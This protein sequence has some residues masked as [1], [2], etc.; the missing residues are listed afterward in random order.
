MFTTLTEENVGDAYFAHKTKLLARTEQTT[1]EAIINELANTRQE[2]AE[3]EA[4]FARG[5]VLLKDYIVL[6][7]E[8]SVVGGRFD[9]ETE[10]RI[11]SPIV[12]VDSGHIATSETCRSVG[13]A[14]R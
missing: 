12:M 9:A 1:P 14:Q 10:A 4:R 3:D 7:S 11:V 5:A 13:L 6:I 2:V 8:R